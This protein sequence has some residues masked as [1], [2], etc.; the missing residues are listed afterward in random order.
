LL[1]EAAADDD[2]YADAD[3]DEEELEMEDY[4]EDEDENDYFVD[5]F[6][7]Y[8]EGDYWGGGRTE[9]YD[10]SDVDAEEEVHYDSSYDAVDEFD[11]FAREERDAEEKEEDEEIGDGD[12]DLSQDA[13][14]GFSDIGESR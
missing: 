12:E 9:M 1:A 8:D 14:E 13:G 10:Y 11:T 5:D 2:D 7:E 4:D 3:V 6:D